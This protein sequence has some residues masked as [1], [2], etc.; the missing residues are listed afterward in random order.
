MFKNMKLGVKISLGFV[1]LIVIAL[2]LGGIAV[3]NMSNVKSTA[4]DMAID[5]VPCITVANEIERQSRM[6]FYEMRAY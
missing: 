5:Y 2:F 3:Y 1:S 4:N 6:A